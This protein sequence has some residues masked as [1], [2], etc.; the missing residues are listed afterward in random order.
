MKNSV[1][2][3]SIRI[4]MVNTTD[5]G[6]IGAVA[7]AMKNM[8]LKHL[9]LVDPKQ[10]PDEKAMRRAA[11][12]LDI[13]D[14]I[15]ITETF[16]QALNGCALVIGTSA[17]ERKIPWPLME[18]RECA[19]KAMVE[20]AQHSVAIVFGRED[21]GL[22]NE[23]LHKCHW[24]LNIPTRGDY[25]SLN[26]AAAA[27]VVCYELLMAYN[28]QTHATLEIPAEEQQSKAD[29]PA[30]EHFYQHLESV[31]IDSQYL[32]PAEPKQTMTRLRK[33]FNRARLDVLELN[34][35]RGILRNLQQKL[36]V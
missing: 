19:E 3:D 6:N 15:V 17:R 31:L 10:R 24:H 25:S 9:Y 12:A 13:M 20:A 2:L 8:G 5:T 27:Q 16:E 1:L 29:L 36:K 21:R 18:V 14:N 30:M 32:D 7:R 22:T 35:L 4:V 11:H 23:E 33:I 34:M 26:V 28:Q